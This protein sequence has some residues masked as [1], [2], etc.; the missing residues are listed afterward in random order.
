MCVG[1]PTKHRGSAACVWAAASQEGNGI[2]CVVVIVVVAIHTQPRSHSVV[3]QVGSGKAGAGRQCLCVHKATK[4]AP[5][6]T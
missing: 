6:H 2:D 4:G 3:Y 5:C 1:L